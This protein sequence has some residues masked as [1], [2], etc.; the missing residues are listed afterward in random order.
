METKGFLVN[1]VV[2]LKFHKII[3]IGS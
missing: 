1:L 3:I 2:G